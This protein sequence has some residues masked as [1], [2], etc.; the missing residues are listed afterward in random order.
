MNRVLYFFHFNPQPRRKQNA[1]G[2][3][4]LNT[5]WELTVE[6]GSICFPPCNSTINFFLFVLFRQVHFRANNHLHIL[7]KFSKMSMHKEGYLLKE[8]KELG[9]WNK[10]YFVMQY[11]MLLQFDKEPVRRLSFLLGKDCK[12]ACYNN[13]GKIIHLISKSSTKRGQPDRTFNLT[14]ANVR[15]AE[16]LH[17][18]D[19]FL[20]IFI[21]T[22]PKALLSIIFIHKT[23]D[24]DL[25]LRSQLERRVE[26]SKKFILQQIT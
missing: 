14:N 12:F 13:H 1:T 20:E 26:S 19:F 4:C 25:S 6:N 17:R 24:A 18:Y 9:F 8:N 7:F 2:G 11:N 3:K 21:R 22:L 10:K 5:M 23:Q 16:G 15:N